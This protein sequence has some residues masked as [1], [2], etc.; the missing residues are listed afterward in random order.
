MLSIKYVCWNKKFK[1]K[2]I[3]NKEKNRKN[4]SEVNK[5]VART[6]NKIEANQDPD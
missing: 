4:Y 1:I 6:F 2:K 3:T 5:R